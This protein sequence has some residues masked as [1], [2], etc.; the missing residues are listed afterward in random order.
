MCRNEQKKAEKMADIERKHSGSGDPLNVVTQIKLV[1]YRSD[2][3][4]SLICNARAST[5]MHKQTIH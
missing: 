3:L 2:W 4:A 5:W 1:Q